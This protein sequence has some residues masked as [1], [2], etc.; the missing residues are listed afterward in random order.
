MPLIRSCLQV[1]SYACAGADSYA[2]RMA[3]AEECAEAVEAAGRRYVGFCGATYCAECCC[4]VCFG[5]ERIDVVV[6]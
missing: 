3:F 2:D 1:P 6:A 5:G 4:V